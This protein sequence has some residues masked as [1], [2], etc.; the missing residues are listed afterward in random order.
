MTPTGFATV[1]AHAPAQL[2]AIAARTAPAARQLRLF[3]TAASPPVLRWEVIMDDQ[4]SRL[5]FDPAAKRLLAVAVNRKPLRIVDARTGERLVEL[6]PA[7]RAIFDAT[8]GRVLAIVP[9]RREADDVVDELVAFDAATGRP[10]QTVHVNL[11]LN[12]L[13]PSPDRSLLALGGA[14]KMVHVFDAATLAERWSFRAHD[15]EITALAFHPREPRLLSAAADHS[16]KLWDYESSRLRGTLLGIDGTP[17]MAAFSPD[18]R[19]LALDSQERLLRLY[20]LDG[21]FDAMPVPEASRP[22]GDWLDL[23]AAGNLSGPA[24][25][26][27]VLTVPGDGEI[28]SCR[29]RLTLRRQSGATGLGFR[30]PWGPRL[31]SFE[32][33]QRYDGMFQ[34]VLGR[35]GGRTGRAGS[36]VALGQRVPDSRPHV[37]EFTFRLAGTRMDFSATLDGAPLCDWSGPLSAFDSARPPTC[38]RARSSL[39]RVVRLGRSP[40]SNCSGSSRSR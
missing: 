21:T 29:L 20:R 18:A 22:E 24:N 32:F 8:G 1:A 3:S 30:L 25:P 5:D 10:L 35:R 33:D 19:L 2:L 16:A 28:G 9:R 6:P 14:D 12:E 27:A 31:V 39:F 4:I 38:R 26:N 13:V 15:A 34:S 11:R 36:G 7:E 37:L 23:L 17:V 40:K